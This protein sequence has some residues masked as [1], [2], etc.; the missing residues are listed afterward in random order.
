[1][2][3]QPKLLDYENTQTLLIGSGADDLS[4]ATAQQSSSNDA[5]KPEK[6]TPL[7]EMEKLE[8]ED[9]AR[10]EHLKGDDSVFMDL[11]L[12]A[13]DYPKMQTTW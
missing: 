1:M 6:D 5:D 4:K 13:K 11:G 9:E 3:L 7:E 2:P 8:A 10:V 12:N